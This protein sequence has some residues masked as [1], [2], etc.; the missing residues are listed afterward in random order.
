LDRIELDGAPSW[1]PGQGI[2]GPTAL[3]LRFGARA[4]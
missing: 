2:V 4:V 3:P 1:L